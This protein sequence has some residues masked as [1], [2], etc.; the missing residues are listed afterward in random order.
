L[1][2]DSSVFREHIRDV[3]N[4]RL[5]RE[6]MAQYR[7]KNEP[8]MTAQKAEEESLNLLVIC[9]VGWNNVVLDGK[10]L[11]FNEANVRK[12]Y[13]SYSWIFDQVNE[14]I[15]QLENFLKN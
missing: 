7:G 9:T 4:E 1:G 10:E 3:L 11:E 15:G 8:A 2:K 13:Q 14:A 12:I 6:S 5:R